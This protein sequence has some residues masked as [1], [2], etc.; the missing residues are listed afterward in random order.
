MQ[1]ERRSE[2]GYVP[3]LLSFRELEF[4]TG[5]LG[6]TIK[7]PLALRDSQTLATSL[8]TPHLPASCKISKAS[9]QPRL[10]QGFDVAIYF[11][12]IFVSEGLC[13]TVQRELGINPEKFCCLCPCLILPAC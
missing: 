9:F 2:C 13:E 3:Y 6:Q 7:T 1:K 11:G 10:A 5:C 4:M 8:N 12:L